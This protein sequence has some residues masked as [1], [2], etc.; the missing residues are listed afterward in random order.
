MQIYELWNSANRIISHYF[1]LFLCLRASTSAED[2]EAL[3]ILK[4]AGKLFL[5]Y[6]RIYRFMFYEK[7]VYSIY[8]VSYG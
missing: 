3:F 4:S 1:Y 6:Q 2:H 7:N 8:A 5:N